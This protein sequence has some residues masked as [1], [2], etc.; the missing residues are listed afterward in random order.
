MSL[1]QKLTG[2]FTTQKTPSGTVI[3]KNACYFCKKKSRDMRTYRNETNQKIK[4]CRLCVELR[5]GGGLGETTD[6][7]SLRR[8]PS[9]SKK[10]RSTES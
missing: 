9:S 3:P 10:I 4:V 7:F 6:R 5:S 2:L 8:I 1:F